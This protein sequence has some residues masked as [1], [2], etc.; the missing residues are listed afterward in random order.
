MEFILGGAKIMFKKYIKIITTLHTSPITFEIKKK[1]YNVWEQT[2]I[3][4]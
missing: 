3:E 4:L 2:K 1:L